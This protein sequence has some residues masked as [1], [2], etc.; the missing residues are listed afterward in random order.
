ME[1]NIVN[2]KNKSIQ[3]VYSQEADKAKG[4]LKYIVEISGLPKRLGFYNRI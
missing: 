1:Q 2:S 3:Q 4:F